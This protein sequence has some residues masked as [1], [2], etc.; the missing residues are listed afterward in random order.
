MR[1]ILS[2][3]VI[4][5][6]VLS[7]SGQQPFIS[8]FHYDDSYSQPQDSFEFVEVYLPDPQPANLNE[9][10]ITLYQGQALPSLDVEVGDIHRQKSF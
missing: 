10:H 8:E 3:L 2:L 9:Y 4:F 7:L 1:S 6:A 5:S